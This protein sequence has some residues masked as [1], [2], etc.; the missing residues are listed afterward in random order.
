MEKEAATTQP[1]PEPLSQVY[2]FFVKPYFERMVKTCMLIS[3][4]E[5]SSGH[6]IVIETIVVKF[7][8]NNGK[9]GCNNP[10]KTSTSLSS[11]LVCP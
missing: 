3:Q 7:W 1:R 5:R 9:R 8:T 6:Y 4:R 11:I 2:L 10:T